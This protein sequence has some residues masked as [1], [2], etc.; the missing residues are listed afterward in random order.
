MV[1][2]RRW[3]IYPISVGRWGVIREGKGME[4]RGMEEEGVV[5]ETNDHFCISAT[6]LF[7]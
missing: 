1:S 7:R 5:G 3:E 6:L 2:A 4:R